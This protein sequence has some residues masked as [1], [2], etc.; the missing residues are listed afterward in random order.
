[1]MKW[2]EGDETVILTLSSP[3]GATL[4]ANVTAHSY[5]IT[6]NE[7]SPHNPV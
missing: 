1:M 5:T 7:S 2:H 6:E 4:G 3:S